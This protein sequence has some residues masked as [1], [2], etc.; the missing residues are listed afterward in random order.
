[1]AQDRFKGMFIIMNRVTK[2]EEEEE[3]TEIAKAKGIYRL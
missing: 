3:A 2:V 1:M